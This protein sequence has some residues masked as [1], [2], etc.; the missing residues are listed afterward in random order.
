M[1]RTGR[2]SGSRKSASYADLV[3]V[4][5]WAEL[6]DFSGCSEKSGNRGEGRGAKGEMEKM[7]RP[8]LGD[9]D[10]GK[11]LYRN[12][13]GRGPRNCDVFLMRP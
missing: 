2:D 8:G 3:I 9:A 7:G 11:D 10:N 5:S 13:S 4:R 1:L 6:V 12:L